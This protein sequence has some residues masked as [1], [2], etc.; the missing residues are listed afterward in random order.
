MKDCLYL[1]VWAPRDTKGG[2]LPVM[3]WLHGGGY[4]GGSASQ[5]HYNGANLAKMGV[6]LVLGQLSHWSVGIYGQS[7]SL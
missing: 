1:N 7:K 2:S 6:I 5:T 4:M 3:F